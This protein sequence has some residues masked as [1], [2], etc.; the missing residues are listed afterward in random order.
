VAHDGWARAR[1]RPSPHRG[2]LARSVA[3]DGNES[4]NH[5]V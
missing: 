5:A 4:R 2:R 3:A 1:Q